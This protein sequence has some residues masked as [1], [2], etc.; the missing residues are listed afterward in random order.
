MAPVS[1]M[2]LL[3]AL[4]AMA[5]ASASADAVAAAAGSRVLADEYKAANEGEE[6]GSTLDAKADGK[7]PGKGKADDKPADDAPAKE[8]SK[9]RSADADDLKVCWL[10]LLYPQPHVCAA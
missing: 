4:A 8:G 10:L 3:L 5:C 6:D 2:L 1:R 9:K 7:K